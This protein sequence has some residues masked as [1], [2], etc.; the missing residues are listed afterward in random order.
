MHLC[1]DGTERADAG[2]RGGLSGS[3]RGLLE[4]RQAQ[5]P[6]VV[7]PPPA[8]SKV[9]ASLPGPSVFGSGRARERAPFPAAG[10]HGTVQE[11]QQ[12]A[13]QGT[14]GTITARSRGEHVGT[15]RSAPTARS[16]AVRVPLTRY[17]RFAS[18]PWGLRPQPSLR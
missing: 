5:E 6:R 8:R 1:V 13:L 10:R 9:G 2:R 11:P 15:A 17:G 4:L 3:A 16:R 12:H 7:A 14:Q 18:L